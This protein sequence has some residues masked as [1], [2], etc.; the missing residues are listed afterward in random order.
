MRKD[1]KQPALTFYAFTL[2]SFQAYTFL[3]LL[4]PSCH[5]PSPSLSPQFFRLQFVSE[6][7][8]SFFQAIAV[9]EYSYTGVSAELLAVYVGVLFVNSAT[10]MFL[11]FLQR[12]QKNHIYLGKRLAWLLLL[13]A[14]CDLFYSTFALLNLLGAL[15]T[16]R[17]EN[18]KLI[19]CEGRGTAM[20]DAK[21]FDA[22]HS[23]GR[24]VFLGGASFTA[25]VVK[26]FSTLFPLV[27]A[28]LRAYNAFTVRVYLAQTN[29]PRRNKSKEQKHR[30]QRSLSSS[31]AAQ[32][33]AVPAT[34]P[35]AADSVSTSPKLRPVKGKDGRKDLAGG[36]DARHPGSIQIGRLLRQRQSEHREMYYLPIP[37]SAVALHVSLALLFCL[38]SWVLLIVASVTNPCGL[39]SIGCAAP[40]APVF[41]LLTNPTTV[42][43]ACTTV[44]YPLKQGSHTNLTD[45]REWLGKF[46]ASR[47]VEYTTVA[48]SA[49]AAGKNLGDYQSSVNSFLKTLANQATQIRTLI[50]ESNQLGWAGQVA[51]VFAPSVQ[52][53]HRSDNPF[54]LDFHHI[55]KLTT[56]EQLKISGDGLQLPRNLE[57]SLPSC[58]GDL[59]N[60]VTLHIWAFN[61]TSLPASLGKLT[62][63]TDFMVMNNNGN[64]RLI[65][66]GLPSTIGHLTSLQRLVR[67]RAGESEIE[68][69]KGN[70]NRYTV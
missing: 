26:A 6:V 2:D 68:R 16:L 43:C 66:T 28:P 27:S 8:E 22:L 42:P 17:S 33:D 58:I 15:F 62:R 18:N 10:P 61:I 64:E 44:V 46:S 29:A 34:P 60:L 41:D 49:F 39:P 7:V 35:P 52:T 45:D 5:P 4:P 37:V 54:S 51:T 38:G 3:P 12:R 31:P 53:L 56:L 32:A 11:A 21:N 55:C 47:A 36:R 13:D 69:A 23:A 63:L 24:D 14:C 67:K 50:V 65:S 19:K 25:I 59:T 20:C 57:G 40:A 48:I 70:P 9:V 1:Y 30:Q